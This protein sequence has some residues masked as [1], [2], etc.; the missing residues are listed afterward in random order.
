[1]TL[2]G[3]VSVL[4]LCRITALPGTGRRR[5]EANRIG[6]SRAAIRVDRASGGVE[7]ASPASLDLSQGD[8]AIWHPEIDLARTGP[9][10]EVLGPISG[11]RTD[12]RAKRTS[13]CRQPLP[14]VRPSSPVPRHVTR[15][16]PRARTL[17]VHH[18]SCP[19]QPSCAPQRTHRSPAETQQEACRSNGTIDGRERNRAL[20][21]LLGAEVG[22]IIIRNRIGGRWRSRCKMNE[23][24]GTKGNTYDAG[25]YALLD[26]CNPPASCRCPPVALG[27]PI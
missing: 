19:S 21:A 27:G 24:A 3:W 16:S 9:D 18:S 1:V 12:P 8:G 4:P 25:S 10:D 22:E 17:H 7:S 13:R 15:M 5:R 2:H 26:F 6:R 11:S 14:P 20:T 23:V